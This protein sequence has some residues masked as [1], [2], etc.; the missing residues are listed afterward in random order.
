VK[1]NWHEV[2]NCGLA[3]VPGSLFA[4]SRKRNRFNGLKRSASHSGYHEVVGDKKEVSQIV[5]SR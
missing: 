1:T 5:Y 4:A 3:N 2:F